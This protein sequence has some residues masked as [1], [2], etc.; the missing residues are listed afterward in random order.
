MEVNKANLL[1]RRHLENDIDHWGDKNA[2]STQNALKTTLCDI[3]NKLSYQKNLTCLL[4]MC[5][6]FFLL[7]ILNFKSK[8]LV[9]ES[10]AFVFGHPVYVASMCVNRTNHR[11]FYSNVIA[12]GLH[13]SLLFKMHW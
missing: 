13:L 2:L 1:I 12:Y 7:K 5:A 8:F 10:D 11:Y 9:Y 3:F 6:I 4:Y